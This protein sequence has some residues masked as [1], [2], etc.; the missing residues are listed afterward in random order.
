MTTCSPE[1]TRAIG[2][3]LG[4]AV[5][6]GAVI[7]LTGDLGSGKTVFVKGIADGIGK[8]DEDEVTSPSFALIHEY[9]GRLPLFH[10]DLYRIEN[11]SDIGELGLEEILES[12]GVVA[13][14]WADR[15]GKEALGDHIHAHF[16]MTDDASRDILLVASGA[17]S[18]EILNHL[19]EELV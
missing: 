16:E 6:S 8:S 19:M 4:E 1:Q 3:K 17:V 5:K 18:V 12:G 13:I 7:A 11:R 9:A 15:I 10:V 2:R 14:E